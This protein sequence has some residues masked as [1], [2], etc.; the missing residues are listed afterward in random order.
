MP[1]GCLVL[2]TDGVPNATEFT[3]ETDP[4]YF[5]DPG[6]D[7]TNFILTMPIGHC[8]DAF[9]L[10][11]CRDKNTNT[12]HISTDVAHYDSEDF[13]RDM[14]DLVSCDPKI[15][16]ADCNSTGQ[17]A[18]MFAIGLSQTVIN[19]KDTNSPAIPYG[20]R[21]LRYVGAVGDDGDPATDACS[22]IAYPTTTD[23]Y[24]CGNYYFSEYGTGLDAVFQQ[25]ASRVFTRI[26][27]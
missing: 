24:D 18:T 23:D 25:I 11:T 21:F 16:A 27:R 14:A 10:G 5:A 9:K 19:S 15:P 6:A 26:T 8:P 7:N 2:L 17:G 12:R 13:A 20:D 22:A 3:A 4:D 1:F